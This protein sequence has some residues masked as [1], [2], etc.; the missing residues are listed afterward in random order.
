M[1]VPI[2][3]WVYMFMTLVGLAR[4]RRIEPYP[5]LVL[6]YEKDKGQCNDNDHV[7]NLCQWH[8][9][10]RWSIYDYI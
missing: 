6:A 7:Y 8:V 10:C 1:F 5:V 3:I 9:Y 4:V 2:R